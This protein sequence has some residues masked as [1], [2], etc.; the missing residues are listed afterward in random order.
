MENE[1][2]TI[3]YFCMEYQKSLLMFP[4]VYAQTVKGKLDLYDG[5]DR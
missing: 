5:Q 4:V 2:Q 1:Q 3:D